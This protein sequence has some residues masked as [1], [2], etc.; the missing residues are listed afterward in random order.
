VSLSSFTTCACTAYFSMYSSIFSARCSLV[1]LVSFMILCN[2]CINSGRFVCSCHK[3][4]DVAYVLT[5]VP[6]IHLYTTCGL[7]LFTSYYFLVWKEVCILV[8]IRV[9]S[10][11]PFNISVSHS[12]RCT[13]LL[14]MIRSMQDL[15]FPLW[16]VWHAIGPGYS[17][18]RMCHPYSSHVAMS[19]GALVHVILSWLF[20]IVWVSSIVG[21]NV[22]TRVFQSPQ[23]T[24]SAFCGRSSRISY[25]NYLV[26]SSSMPLLLRFGAGGI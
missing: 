17:P 7:L 14:D 4:A 8:V 22:P 5:P 25:I 20:L 15:S 6:S 19:Q 16:K 3:F 1:L 21:V 11:S 2:S 9:W 13:D 18:F 23:M 24:W 12:T 26:S 10:D